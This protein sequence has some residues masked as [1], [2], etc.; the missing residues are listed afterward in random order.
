MMKILVKVLLHALDS[1]ARENGWFPIVRTD[2][3]IRI[4]QLNANS[5]TIRRTQFPVTLSWACTVQKVQGL[6]LERAVISF[7]LNEQ[8]SFKAGQMYV[9]L[10]RVTNMDGLYLTV[11]YNLNDI[12]VNTNASHEYE[13]LQLES[14]FIPTETVSTSH[15]RLVFVLLNCRFLTKHAIDF[16]ND[17]KLTNCDAVFLTETQILP[18]EDVSNL[19]SEL[20]PSSAHL[21][22]NS[23]PYKFSILAILYTDTIDLL[24]HEKHNGVS[25]IKLRKSSFLNTAVKIVFIYRINGTSIQKFC[26]ELQQLIN[27]ESFDFIMGDFNLNALDPEIKRIICQILRDYCLLVKDPTHLGGS[28][29]DHVILIK[30][31]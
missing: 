13:R 8:R 4:K 30:V 5:L 23:S 16:A 7:D 17:N 24:Y 25:F 9:A 10:S 20:Q 21:E 2:T 19:H 14:P 1:F 15:H 22:L 3:L 27:L 6:S 26:E 12:K 28:L 18:A 11:T 31:G 29:L